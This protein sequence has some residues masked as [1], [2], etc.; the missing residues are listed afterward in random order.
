[1]WKLSIAVFVVGFV[2]LFGASLH[3][4]RHGLA[5]RLDGVELASGRLL[6]IVV[7]GDTDSPD[8]ALVALIPDAA[9]SHVI[10]RGLDIASIDGE[11]V[12][13]GEV[14]EAVPTV[15]R[16]G[17]SILTIRALNRAY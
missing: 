15:D 7:D 13:N 10:G 9:P 11:N 4:Q 16:S 5:V 2:D 17:R 12:F 1:M 8:A 6:S 3:A 14:M